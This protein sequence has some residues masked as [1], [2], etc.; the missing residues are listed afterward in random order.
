MFKRD[1][2]PKTT[3]FQTV[4]FKLKYRNKKEF[5]SIRS[6]KL[7]NTTYSAQGIQIHLTCTQQFRKCKKSV[8]KTSN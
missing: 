8:E 2:I 5:L 6:I 4:C 1:C 3:L 7:D